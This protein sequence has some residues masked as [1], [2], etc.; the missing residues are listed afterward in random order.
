MPDLRTTRCRLLAALLVVCSLSPLPAIAQAPPYPTSP[1]PTAPAHPRDIVARRPIVDFPPD[2]TDPVAMRCDEL[3]DH[4]ADRQR[5]GNGVPFARIDVPAALAACGRAAAVRPPRPRYQYLYGRA[6]Q[7]AQRPA[8]AAALYSQA[9]Q[10]GFVLGAYQLALLYASGDGVPRDYEWALAL[11]FRAGNAGLADAFATGGS[12]YLRGQPA[13][14]KEAV[15]WFEHAAQGGSTLGM[16]QLAWMTLRGR[17]TPRNPARAAALYGEAAR[18]GDTEGMYRL[19]AMYLDG[20]GMA[21]DL[22]TALKWIRPAA[23]A[24]HE[25]AQVEMG[26]LYYWGIGVGKDAR[27]AF[28][29]YLRAAQAGFLPGQLFVATMYDTGD[30][31]TQDQGQAV[32]WYRAAAEQDDARA[33]ALLGMHLRTGRGVAR[34]EAEALQ[35]LRKAAERKN[36]GAQNALA[37]GYRNAK[38]YRQAAYW[39]GEAARQGSAFAKLHLA[40]LYDDGLGVARDPG[41]AR[42][43]YNEAA[44]S[45]E[46]QVA[47]AA[48]NILGTSAGTPGQPRSR[49]DVRSADSSDFWFGLLFGF[50]VVGGVAA[51]TSSGSS[52]SGSNVYDHSEPYQPQKSDMQIWQEA[53]HMACVVTLDT[54]CKY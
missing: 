31:V 25:F 11:S 53:Q 15:S 19:G 12:L 41:R 18:R 16:T 42:A 46:P 36:V 49:T 35:W 22:A 38:D 33:M 5:V 39:F 44:A 27:V 32:R 34:N 10:G 28:G 4:P 9:D 3:A 7:A 21:K 2:R 20:N 54:H 37:L 14:D 1:S 48:R 43:L 17:G 29:W 30:G 13:N 52:S 26:N 40:L 23:E 50:L 47:A 45:S 24:G 51:L 6:L 8:E